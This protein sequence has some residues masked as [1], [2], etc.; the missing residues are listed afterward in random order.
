MKKYIS[1]EKIIMVVSFVLVIVGLLWFFSPE[2]SKYLI[3]S[4]GTTE[5]NV[6]HEKM[7]ENQLKATAFKPEEINP[8]STSDYVSDYFSESQLPVVGILSIPDINMILP[9]FNGT[10]NETMSY[11]AGTC[12]PNQV[13][14]KGNYSLASHTIFNMYSGN[15]MSGVLFGN[16]IY[17]QI[18]QK[19]YLT[20]KDKVFEYSIDNIYTVNVNQGNIIDDHDKKDEITLYTCTRLTGEERLVVHGN[21]I[22]TSSYTAN[23]SIFE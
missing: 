13:M 17:A 6:S 22:Q 8:K 20:D 15:V 18:G 2:L 16:L 21:L 9:V 23:H 12:K 5:V 7:K 4:K 1:K 10:T 14:G 11:G 19:I 3:R